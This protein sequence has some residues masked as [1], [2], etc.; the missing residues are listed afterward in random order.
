M[1]QLGWMLVV[2]AVLLAGGLAERLARDAARRAVPIRIHVNGTRGKSTVTRLI[3]AALRAAGVP[4][5]AK[6]TGTLPR[7]I[8]SD[9]SERPVRRRGLPNIR[10]QLRTLWLARRLGLRAVV[11]ECM[12]IHPEMQWASEHDMLAATIGVVTNVR[13]DHG[14]VMGKS[15]DEVAQTLA[16]T[17]PS[18]AV[19][20]LGDASFAAVFRARAAALGTRVVLAAPGS[21]TSRDWLE[22]DIATALAVTGELGIPESVA[23]A[24]M[25][26]AQPDPGACR[27]L[28]V[29]AGDRELPLLDARAAND[30]D[31]L[32]RLLATLPS[33]P[34]EIRWLAVYNH[35]D[36]RPER[37]RAFAAFLAS[38]RGLDLV[39]TGD[40]PAL[41]LRLALRR[42]LGRAVP[43]VPRRAWPGPLAGLAHGHDAVVLCGNTRGLEPTA[44]T[45]GA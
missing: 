4:T 39:L 11:L 29:R 23:R 30:P 7:L 40:P 35:R 2:S 37:L 38:R 41:S 13:T 14:E 3:A 17:I 25:T 5:L 18:R 43:H 19:L 16:N 12:A 32:E 31:S 6:V 33:P 10:E 42:R 34:G 44:L 28:R 22:E 8:L 21:A 26:A 45:G 24:A 36:D 15:L 20:V 9:G 27:L 1:G